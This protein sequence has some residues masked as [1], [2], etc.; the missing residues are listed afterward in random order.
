MPAEI[1]IP[2]RLELLKGSISELQNIL[3]NLKPN[4]QSFRTISKYIQDMTKEMTQFQ[5]LTSRAFSNQSQFNRG[6]KSIER[7]ETILDKAKIAMGEIK[8]PEIKLSGEQQAQ[9]DSLNKT[10]EDAAAKFDQ[11]K[12]KVKGNILSDSTTQDLFS[13][14]DPKYME[15]N[16]D[17]LFDMVDRKTQELSR[18]MVN[19]KQ[20][21]A[22][23]NG[24]KASQG[25][26]IESCY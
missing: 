2:V 15:K 4:T 9:W 21:L 13:N 23:F 25:K 6:N 12:E 20:K 18:K 5:A 11:I 10:L 16:F 26:R 14:M 7:M 22:E 1:N 8:F 3:S 17:Q 19:A 24:Q